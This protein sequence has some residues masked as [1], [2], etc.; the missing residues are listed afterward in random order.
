MGAVQTALLLQTLRLL[1]KRQNCKL[2]KTE[3]IELT[4]INR[5]RLNIIGQT[6]VRLKI[7][8][9]LI[10]TRVYVITNMQ[11]YF[12]IGNDMIKNT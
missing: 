8:Q 6:Y 5:N 12:I 9:H 11:H 10:R 1:R 4:A 7:G 3:N 2:Y